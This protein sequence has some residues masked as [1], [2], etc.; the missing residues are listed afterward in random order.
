VRFVQ[1]L[2]FSVDDRQSDICR[3]IQVHNFRLLNSIDCVE[4]TY[5]LHNGC[6][7]R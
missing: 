6:N 3:I 4:L 2:N 5:F 7:V 1:P